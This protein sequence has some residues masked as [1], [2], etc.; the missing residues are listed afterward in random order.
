MSDQE[1]PP[2]AD[3]KRMKHGCRATKLVIY[4]G[5]EEEYAEFC[6]L[7]RAE[8]QPESKLEESVLAQVIDKAWQ[9]R[10][11]DQRFCEVDAVT[12]QRQSC[13]PHRIGHPR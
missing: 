3:L 9:E 6:E 2:L 12:S 1:L 13:S 11:C 8:Y 10:R 7:W 4:E 5:E